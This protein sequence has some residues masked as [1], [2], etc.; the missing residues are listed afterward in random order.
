MSVR[1][2]I[3]DCRDKLREM[4]DASLNCCV[5][6]PPFWRQRDYEVDGQLGVEREPS[7]FAAELVGIMREVRRVL[8]PDGS[9]WLELG[10]T[11]AA[12]GNGGGGSRSLKRRKLESLQR[13]TGWRSPPPGYKHRDLSLVPFL[14]A[15]G[16]RGDGW[17][18]RKTIIWDKGTATEPPRL[19][20]PS[21]SHSYL[22]LLTPAGP[23]RVRNPGEPWF[24]S[25]VWS[26]APGSDPIHPAPMAR[27]IVRRCIVSATAPGDVVLDPFGGAGTTGLVADRMQRDAILIELNPEYAELARR[28]IEGDS[29]LF[30]QVEAA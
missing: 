19:D 7:G 3:G 27:E 4:P 26:V 22:F 16:L 30:A 25:S 21:V 18:L 12:G 23:S 20:R 10:D 15:D 14:V 29:S 11:Y 17:Y 1:I 8:R 6:S 2:L 9:L 13:R 24:T 28:R 5:T